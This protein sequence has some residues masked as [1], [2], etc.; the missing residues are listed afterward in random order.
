MGVAIKEIVPKREI[1]FDELKAKKIALDAYN[2]L[3]QFLSAIRQ[4]DGTPLLDR[5]GR[6]TSHLSGLFYRTVKLV[7]LGIQPVYV[8]DGK[9]PELKQ[10]TLEE[11]KRHREN[12]RK[13]WEEAL[14]KGELGEARK[15][16]QAASKLDGEMVTDAK[17]LLTAMGIP[18]VQAPSEGEA[19][20]AYMA[21]KGDVWASGSQD[22]DSLLFG[23]DRLVRNL[24][25]V[26][27][28][29][30]PGKNI[31]VDVAPE[32]I[33]LKDVLKT[34]GIDRKK[35]IWIGILVGTDFNEKVPGIGP[36]RALALVKEHS[37]LDEIFRALGYKPDYDW[38]EVE[39]IFLEPEVTDE[40]ATGFHRPDRDK[41]LEILVEKHDFSRERV[42]KALKTLEDATPAG[43]AQTSLDA[44]FG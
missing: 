21:S 42:E 13:K 23:A 27:K 14:E 1:S 8:F 36:K 19:Q 38:E 30:L 41:V 16:A 5:K 44:W 9:P 31:Y 18:W 22:Y 25:V 32:L 24:A 26:G 4:P 40:Y 28:R 10:K 12:A 17:E 29:K 15:Y 2:A 7:E 35:L 11:R 43:G 6:V 3:Y 34:L 20:A 37:S 33:Q 39:K